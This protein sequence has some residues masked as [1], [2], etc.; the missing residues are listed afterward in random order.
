MEAL[1]RSYEKKNVF[2]IH[3]LGGDEE[4]PVLHFKKHYRLNYPVI[5]DNLDRYRHLIRVTGITNVA[6]F[7]GD[8]V[9]VLNESFMEGGSGSD[10]EK[11]I[12]TALAKLDGPNRRGAAFIDAGTVYAPPVKDEGAIVRQRT[13]SLAA[14]PAGEL[15]LAYSSDENGTGDVLLRS[16]EGGKWSKDVPVA[17]TKADEYAP[18]TVSVGKGQALVAFVSNEKGLYDIHTAVVKDGKVQK[19]QQ[20]TKSRNDAMA[21][22]LGGGGKVEPWLAWYEWSR[23]GDLSRD[24]EVF[25]A[26]F[27]RGGWSR[28]IQVSPREVPAYEDHADPSIAPDGKGGAWV[29]WAWDYHGT[30]PQKPPVDENSIFMRRVDGSMKLGEILAAGFRGS[31]R[32]RDYTPSVAIA[33]DGIPW[34]AWDNSHKS[35]L[36]YNAKALFVNRL[37]GKDFEDQVEG[38]ASR[39]AIDS[40]RLLADPKG[41]LHLLWNQDGGGTWEVWV[42]PI[43]TKSMGEPRRLELKA[44]N[45]R[46]PAACFDSSGRLWVAYSD[47]VRPRWEVRVEGVEG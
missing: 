25:A 15:H 35:S 12:D 4:L 5:P 38:A 18:T 31:G 26:A 28:P 41:G 2:F 32:A 24:R 13:P 29:A 37:T 19:R 43:G 14:G 11:A 45:P 44:K 10:F 9:C 6:V 17:S 30:L 20:I 1:V 47:A 27:K 23:M 8:G 46:Y 34:V 22:A 21:P 39:G 16:F 3:T 42:R 40:P 36:G 7:G 33:S